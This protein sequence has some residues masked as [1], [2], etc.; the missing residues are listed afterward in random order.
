VQ[1]LVAL[2][3]AYAAGCALGAGFP[4]PIVPAI[5]AA[6]SSM[7]LA[8]ACGWIR[9][10]P[11]LAAVACALVAGWCRAPEAAERGGVV[12]TGEAACVRTI[13]GRISRPPVVL[14]DGARFE[15]EAEAATACAPSPRAPA[16]AP[17][18]AAVWV[19]VL[20]REAP[21]V[22]AGDRVIIR[23]AVKRG[24]SLR[25]FGARSPRARAGERLTAVVES[26][27]GVAVLSRDPV[28]VGVALAAV[29]ERISSF[30]RGNLAAPADG[31]ARALVIGES[32]ALDPALRDRF[33]RT[34]TAHLVA[35]SGLHLAILTW[36]CFG[37]LRRA[38]LRVEPLA[39]RVEVGRIAAAATIP[40]L[41]AFAVMVGGQPP[42]ARSCVMASCVLVARALVRRARA[43]EALALAAVALLAFDPADVADPGFQLSFAAVT[44]FF[45]AARRR[46][47]LLEPDGASAPRPLARRL[48]GRIAAES[49]RLFLGSLA[50]AAATT[51]I[52]LY[53]FDQASAVAVPC[54]MIAIPFTT[55]LVMP[56][57]FLLSA[58][59]IAAPQIAALG[60]PVVGWMLGALATLLEWAGRPDAASIVAPGPPVAIA[61]AG[62]C[63]AALAFVALRSPR[64]GCVL[65][66]A[67]VATG[68]LVRCAPPAVPAG[69]LVVDFLDVGQGSAALVT[70]P[71]GRRWLVDAGGS[72][73]G[74]ERFGALHLVPTLRGLGVRAIDTVVLS[75]PD[76]DHVVGAADLIRELAV[77]RVLAHGTAA[78]AD[79]G[80]DE[81][82]RAGYVA[83]LDAARR[84]GVTWEEPPDICGGT[85]VGAVRVEVLHPCGGS[86]GYDPSLSPND[87]SLVIRLSYGQTSALLPGDLGRQGEARLLASG[88]ALSSDVLAL[89]HH[90]SRSSSGAAFLDAVRP[91]VAVASA[92]RGN[93]WRLPDGEVISALRRRG[94][95][96]LR[97]DRH[98]GVRI[99][100]DGAGIAVTFAAGAPRR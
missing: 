96:L 59:A 9:R 90:G 15:L 82:R 54:N 1:I 30:W 22:V 95:H 86:G 27:G 53:H 88:R 89:G 10:R 4:V 99:V 21:Q 12:A 2:A 64:S 70:F 5:V 19:T 48:L 20:G 76:A 35:V 68:A 83:I 41:L 93:P 73:F 39:R 71:D 6:G 75:H 80:E 66:A 97:T 16:L 78:V 49:K 100:S 94:V 40:V 37:A 61:I 50:A 31:L 60:A 74:R 52:A 72:A 7:A 62:C 57:L 26:A 25:N 55:V 87:N 33:R 14:E 44:S 65:L 34:G 63:A 43:L 46:G 69:R 17:L 18:R 79:E 85:D 29:R 28:A 56:A 3:A 11:V 91:A 23:G 98:G 24:A 38:L 8:A 36:L 51:P 58:V 67:L 81:A 47:R 92:G 13:V 42:V 32:G 84:R 45:L 77:R